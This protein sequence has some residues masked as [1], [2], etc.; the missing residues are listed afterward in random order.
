M[1]APAKTGNNVQEIHLVTQPTRWELAPGYVVDAWAY[2]G[3]V[4]GP[5][6]HVKEGERIRVVLKNDLPEPTTI[7]WHGVDV[8]NAM[9]GVPGVTQAPVQP[10]K[11]FVYEFMATPAGT[12]WYHTHFNGTKQLDLGL[13]G[14]LIIEPAE[15][16]P[17]PFDRDYTLVLGGWVTGKRAAVSSTSGS[18]EG[19]MMGGMGRG[20]MMGGMM[21]WMREGMNRMMGGGMG[22]MMEG[23]MQPHEP[24]YNTFTINSK[25]FPTTERLRVRQGERVRLRLVNATG[26]K[27]HTMRLAGHHMRVTHTDGNPLQE[28]VKVDAVAL[29]P[30]E[31]YDV[32]FDAT[33][34]GIWPLY[35]LESAHTEAG[36]KTLVVYE[37]AEGNSEAPSSFDTAGL[38]LWHYTDGHG[39]DL[40]PAAT[41]GQT[42]TFRLTL[43]GGMM[44]LDNWTINGKQYPHTDPLR[45]QKGDL[46]RVRISNMSME[47]HPMHL[48]GHSFR[49]L[50][51]NGQR[52]ASPLV[53]DAV[54]VDAH[55]GSVD[56]EFTAHNPGDWFFHCHKTMHMEGGMLTLVKVT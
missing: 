36:L 46:V 11:T 2:N 51:V 49:V 38:R 54:D 26:M 8:P 20:G 39:R 30:S 31:R 52:L 17:F 21:E 3:Q 56:I 43:S 42:R 55:M 25:A 37:G 9:D 23:M 16:D 28:P 45:V 50:A 29:A 19:C 35:A 13:Q 18:M 34:P 33:N 6:I 14:A 53:K 44:G 15:G 40:L 41:T 5:V 7:H 22:R 1:A 10:G 48:H 32:E 4:P 12:R 47:A 24:A 27:T